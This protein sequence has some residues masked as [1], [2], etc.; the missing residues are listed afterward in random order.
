MGYYK[1]STAVNGQAYFNLYDSNN[2]K[3]LT[4]ETYVSAYG[5]ERG[6]ASCQINSGIDGRY[7]SFFGNDSR[8][9]FRLKGANG[10]II[11]RSEGYYSSAGRDQGKR[12]VM[13]EGPASKLKS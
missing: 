10:E 13:K 7:E 6:I 3:I 12:N 8:Y 9:Y 4:S 2:E 1:I 11:G 5:A